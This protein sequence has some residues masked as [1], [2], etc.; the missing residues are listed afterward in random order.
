MPEGVPI[1]AGQA[2]RRLPALTVHMH[3]DSAFDSMEAFRQAV[4][5]DVEQCIATTHL[6]SSAALPEED[7]E[8]AVGSGGEMY[9]V[10]LPILAVT[11]SSVRKGQGAPLRLGLRPE[12]HRSHASG[13]AAQQVTRCHETGS[14]PQNVLFRAC[15][16]QEG[17]RHAVTELLPPETRCLT[18]APCVQAPSARP[19][20]LHRQSGRLP[21]GGRG[22]LSRQQPEV[23]RLGQLPRMGSIQR[24]ARRQPSVRGTSSRCISRPVPAACTSLRCVP[25]MHEPATFDQPESRPARHAVA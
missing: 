15:I 16:W 19:C 9:T 10:P 12:V 23:R 17:A 21:G 25:A 1:A 8:P 4:A 5:R 2:G 13:A 14:C 18:A 6:R 24:T 22:R 7:G 3:Q 20:V 11:H